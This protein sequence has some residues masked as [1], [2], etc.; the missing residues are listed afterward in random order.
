MRGS[1]TATAVRK[2]MNSLP[3]CDGSVGHFTIRLS[4]SIIPTAQGE[5]A[6]II[7]SRKGSTICSFP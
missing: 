2:L 7:F 1:F 3:A 5:M 6:C 4:M